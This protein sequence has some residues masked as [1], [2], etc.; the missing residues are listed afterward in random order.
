MPVDRGKKYLFK[1]RYDLTGFPKA[2]PSLKYISKVVADFL[3]DI[4]S[5]Y[6]LPLRVVVDG[7]PENVKHMA[8][9]LSDLGI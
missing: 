8:D 6:G 5:D 4:I 2:R 1:A 7:G 3:I 9:A